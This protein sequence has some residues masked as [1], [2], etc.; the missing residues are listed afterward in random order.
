MVVA[1]FERNLEFVDADVLDVVP[2]ATRRDEVTRLNRRKGP[3]A[4]CPR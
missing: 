4:A 1:S 2:K 3:D